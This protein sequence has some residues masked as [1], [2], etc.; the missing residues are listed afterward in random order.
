M[1]V[2]CGGGSFSIA[3][4]DDIL[5]KVEA[6]LLF[7]SY[8]KILVSIMAKKI[9]FGSNHIVIDLP[10]GTNV[11]V[12]RLADAEVLK[13][14]FLSLAEKFNVKMRVLVHKV[15]EPAGR[16]LGPLLEARE[17][18][19]VLEQ[20]PDRPLDLEDRALNLAGELLDLCL[21]D[22]TEKLREEISMTYGTSRA[23]AKHLLSSG[24]ALAKM[25]EIIAAQ[26]GDPNVKSTDLTPG[27]YSYDYPSP[28]SG[29]INGIHSKN[30]TV[31]AKILGAP[32]HKKAGIYLHKKVGDTVKK[33]ETLL[34]IYSE[35]NHLL[36]E[37]K[38]S[39]PHFPISLFI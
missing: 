17:A 39:L 3:P 11:K 14:K 30:V 21:E 36:S 25:K 5:I 9:A 23:W 29:E 34:T 12:H 35:S 33:G 20:L 18:V 7:E 24:Q 16:G 38:D 13:K 22:S 28:E 32:E 26:G 4:A 37:A 19:R 1:L 8:D 2:L 31:I 27:K 15:E 10:Y 6:P